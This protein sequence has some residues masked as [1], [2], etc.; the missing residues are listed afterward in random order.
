MKTQ[1]LNVLTAVILLMIP[2]L[3]FAQ[4]PPLGTAAQ[5]VLFSTVGAVGNT[6]ISQV[7]G[8]VGTNSGAITGFGNVNGVMLTSNGATA[9][10]AADLLIAYNQL[11]STV[12]NF[13]PAP[14]LGNGQILNAGVYSIS[15]AAT[16]NLDLI[17]NGQGNPGAVFIFKIQGP[18][19]TGANSKVKLI[20]GALACNVFWKVEGLVSMAAGT[21]MRGTVI[22]N[23]AAINMS[24]GDT[25]EGR[26]L[27]TTG[28]VNVNGI[29][30]YT[31]IG[32]GSPV[33]TGP[34]A[35]ALG[36]T[37]CYALLSASGPVSNA[38]VT[39]AT[40]DIGTNV[41]LT[42]GFNPLFVTGT[43][44]PIP[45]ASTAQ[46]AADLGI[47][48]TYLNTLPVDIELLYPA[49]FGNDFV[50]TPHT[51]LLNAATV[52]TGNLYL[53]AQGNANAVFV[54]KINGALSTST[55]SKVLFL[56]GTLAKNVYWKV[57]GA[58]SINDY[59]EFKGTIVCNNG[60]MLLATGVTLEGRALTTTGALGTTAITATMPPGCGG[61]LSPS[62]SSQPTNQIACVGTSASFSVT[63]TGTSLTYQWRKGTVNLTNGGTI[64]GATAATLTINPVNLSDAALNYNVVITGTFSP[65]VTSNNVSLTVNPLPVATIT[66]PTPVCLG[67]TGN[68]YTTQPAMTN[69]I[70]VVSAGGTITSGGTSTSNSV[71]VTWNTLL[72]KTVSVTYIN[73]NGCNAAA[74]IFNVTINPLPVP[75][76]NGSTSMCANSGFYDY[77]TEA[78]MTNYIWA[79]SAGG[80]ITWGTGSNQIQV[81]WNTPGAQTVSVTYNNLT[82]CLPAAPATINVTVNAIPGNAGNITGLTE[83]C[84]GA[85][86]INYST[87]QIANAAS[88]V[89]TLPVGAT[90]VNGAGTPDISVNFAVNASSG[91]IS[92]SGNNLCGNGNTSSIAI[93]VNPI[94]ITPIVTA[95]G[96]ILNSNATT[97]NQWY[98]ENVLIPGATGQTYQATQTG[99]YVTVVTQNGCS[100]ENSNSVYFVLTGLQEFQRN[101]INIY[102]VPNDG[103]FTVSIVSNS[104]ESY[105]I[106]VFSNLGNQIFEVKNIYVNG[107]FDEV[108]DLK[109]VVSG[110]YSVLIRNNN[111]HI[112]KKVMVTK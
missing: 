46:A 40:G 20:N 2:I 90:I 7:T 78:G 92:V 49:Q 80:T 66:G 23:N 25:L 69:Y 58:V 72:L 11:N 97:G 89:W 95:N 27:S 101:E 3:S 47:A 100:S 83:V 104:L 87:P 55:Y 79:I 33:L 34:A 28:A 30:A 102:P 73:G 5:F 10:C 6:G 4:A 85:M 41:G 51:Y 52:F 48:Y 106:T 62:I 107:R 109:P 14:L 64:S 99:W 93:I 37:Q 98:F 16:L 88:Y 32:C 56:N 61:T 71:T 59:S 112:V 57:D 50:L 26:A 67:S 96:D 54:I 36:T 105:T 94:P 18:F 70:W 60:A 38:G 21:F 17:L 68:V 1:F 75:T 111:K 91:N 65:S 12:P 35:P 108:I 13:F 39:H 82:G 84:A 8:N 45:D 110:I 24:I 76:L 22:A 19:S 74:T 77:V 31:P 43:I 44:H 103:R 29:L 63:A 9:Q 81:L 42:T 15:G 86:G 53:N